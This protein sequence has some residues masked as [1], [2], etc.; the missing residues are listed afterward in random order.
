MTKNDNCAGGVARRSGNPLFGNKRAFSF[1][2]APV[3]AVRPLGA[4][5]RRLLCVCLSCFGVALAGRALPSARGSRLGAC[6]RLVAILV[7]PHPSRRFVVPPTAARRPFLFSQDIKKMAALSERATKPSGTP[8]YKKGA[9]GRRAGTPVPLSG[10]VSARL[11][12]LHT[13]FRQ[14]VPL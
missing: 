14:A 3:P 8:A 5:S 12:P 4:R 6:R 7:P 10:S 2:S 13:F 11:Q 9:S 1:C